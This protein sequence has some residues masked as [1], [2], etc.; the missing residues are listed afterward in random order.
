LRV[1]VAGFAAPA[2]LVAACGKLDLPPA[3]GGSDAAVDHAGEG[4]IEG[5][6]SADAADGARLDV[7]VDAADVDASACNVR[8]DAPPI[9]ESPHVPE[10][11]AVT[12]ASNPPS[13]GPHYPVW[14]NFQEL[15]HPVDDG[16]LVH[17]LEHGA[18]LLLYRCDLLDAACA[19][20]VATLRAV[21]DAVPTDPLCDPAIR[22]RVIIAPRP[23][24]DAAIAASAWGFTYRA[25][26]VDPASLAKF[27]ADHYAKAPENVCAPG[28]TL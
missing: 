19:D 13:S 21:R 27:V 10:G 23:A 7:V 17:S 2:F 25:D 26:C 8:L 6:P 28:S 12:Y 16:Y 9:V 1:V 20:V 15:T 14:A 18:V 5:A 24:N 11:T 3:S 22:V 4:A